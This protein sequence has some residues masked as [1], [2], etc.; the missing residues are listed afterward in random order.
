MLIKGMVAEIAAGGAIIPL[1]DNTSMTYSSHMEYEWDSA[2]AT[3]NLAKHGVDFPAAT[4]ALE[5]P[6][7]LV[8]VD[9]RYA[10]PRYRAIG[11]VNGVVLSV[12]YT[13]RGDVCRIIS[14]RRASRRERETYHCTL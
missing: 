8:I 6:G 2:K 14:A 11:V 13:M 1:A 12:A 10:E 3:S 9:E 5:D 7:L 4:E